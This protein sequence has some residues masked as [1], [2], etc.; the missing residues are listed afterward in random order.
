[1]VGDGNEPRFTLSFSSEEPYERFFGPEILDH[2]P[3]AVDLTRLN[4]MGCLLFNH[5]RDI[6]IG[7]I[8]RAWIENHRGQAEV[9]FD[10]DA[11]S[12]VVYQKVRNGTL[13]GVSV[14]YRIDALEEIQQGKMSADGRFSGPCA[15]A[16]KWMPYE[17]SIVSVPADGTVGVGRE[18]QKRNQETEES[19]MAEKKNGE[20]QAE[21][22]TPEPVQ[23]EK[24]EQ[25]APSPEMAGTLSSILGG[26]A[27]VM[28]ERHEVLQQ[29]RQRNM[30]ITALCRDFD[31]DPT[32]YI[33]DGNSTDYVRKLVLDK[34]KRE[35]APIPSGIHVTD[36]GEDNFRRDAADGLLLRGGLHP[37][38]VTD[39][40]RRFS[41][42]SLRDLA[43][44][45]QTR[46]GNAGARYLDSDALF[47]EVFQRQFFNPTAAF[48]S[49]LDNAIE[50]AYVEGHRTVPVTFDQWTTKGTLKDFKIHDNNYLAGAVGEFLEVPEGGE[51]KNDIPKDAKRPTRQLKT[52]GKQ[53]TLSRQAFINDDIGLVTRIPARYA[54]A[55][56]KTINTQ[57]YR[58]LMTNPA[59]YD[60]TV[61][62]STNHGNLLSE[63]TGINQVAMQA[64]IMALSTQK[65]E[66]DQA[67][68]VR[69]DKVIVPAGYSFDIFTMFNSP[70]IHSGDNTQAVNPL[71]R[72]KDSLTIIEDP[73]INQ[74][75]GGWGNVMPWFLRAVATDSDFI[76]VDYLNGQEIPTIRR[77]EAPGQ[78]GF[79]WDIY[80]DWGINIM[81]FR[82]CIKNPGVVVS[83]P[84]A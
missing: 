51:L 73:T 4:G 43:I 59:I 21:V 39:G 75:A 19:N 82:G 33:R 50:K 53:F 29:E 1:M 63:G 80:L 64:M 7:K 11:Q 44:E 9:E 74:L 47:M 56:R 60:G 13:K 28:D 34:L 32:P 79:V 38:A 70:Y 67:I 81:D 35:R 3:A 66:F 69:P 62:F 23:G 16:R 18:A 61:L 46:E 36:T 58:I 17:I 55:A 24:K 20:R 22:Q 45:C 57:C 48:P 78:L 8:V 2:D 5:N 72:Y 76:E 84:L 37:E 42:L 40:A 30:E 27:V 68:I 41:I 25:Q 54:A 15:V 77:M 26:T 83:N 31:M 71:Y 12:E 14:G 49:I 6:V 65:D 52:Y 10:T